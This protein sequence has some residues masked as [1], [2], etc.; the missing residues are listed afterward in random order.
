M[1]VHQ[2]E[3]LPLRAY[4]Y[5]ETH[6]V[7]V[8]LTRDFGQL[9]AMA[10][11]A[12]SGHRNRYGSSLERLTHIRLTFSRRQHQE[13]SVVQ[14]C[15]IIRAFPDYSLNWEINLHL[16]YF[17][18]LLVEF[19]REEEEAEHLFRLSLAVLDA[20]GRVPP[21][22]VARYFELWLLKLDGVL[23]DLH[24]KLP[25]PLAE[26]AAS[27]L[28]LHPSELTPEALTEAQLKRLESV[29]EELIEYH[30]EKR[31]KSKRMLKELL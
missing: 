15:E 13:L 4:S 2:S 29:A 1:S 18:E 3:A 7:V 20:L 5:A 28:R 17:A 21:A 12:K 6:K 26:A 30:L 31:L 9:R 27:L 23:P 25:P 22:L 8:F 14:Q 19:S 16:S 11:G 10:Y 24:R